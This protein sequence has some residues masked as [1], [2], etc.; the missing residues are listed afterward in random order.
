[1]Q[2]E[3]FTVASLRGSDRELLLHLAFLAKGDDFDLHLGEAIYVEEGWPLTR[4][5]FYGS[6]GTIFSVTDGFLHRGDQ[7]DEEEEREGMEDQED[8]EISEAESDI[9]MEE[10]DRSHFLLEKITT[11]N[12]VPLTMDCPELATL[13]DCK[14]ELWGYSSGSCDYTRF[15]IGGILKE[16]DPEN[17]LDRFQA[18]S[19]GGWLT[20]TWRR[21]SVLITPTD[22]S[23]TK[24]TLPTD[25]VDK[26]YRLLD[27]S[28]STLPS[29]EELIALDTA[30]RSLRGLSLIEIRSEISARVASCLRV[31]IAW[32]NENVFVHMLR[33]C[34]DHII[35]W[36][37]VQYL[38][39]GYRTFRWQRVE[40][41]YSKAVTSDISIRLRRELL[42]EMHAVATNAG[43]AE[44]IAWFNSQSEA[45]VEN[46][47]GFRI[48]MDEVDAVISAVK[49]RNDPLEVIR[50]ILLPNLHKKQPSDM[51]MWAT[52]FES[53]RKDSSFDQGQL[54]QVITDCIQHL[55]STFQPF[56]QSDLHS[57]IQQTVEHVANFISLCIAYDS[58]DTVPFFLQRLWDSSTSAELAVRIG[59]FNALLPQLH[60][61]LDKDAPELNNSFDEFFGKVFDLL[62]FNHSSERHGNLQI[63]SRYLYNPV[64]RLSECLSPERLE[65]LA[66]KDDHTLEDVTKFVHVYCA[67]ANSGSRARLQDI[68]QLCL[69]A[70]L[71]TFKPSESDGSKALNFIDLCFATDLR[72]TISRGF[73]T[74][75]NTS[76]SSQSNYI[77]SQLVTILKGLPELL[78][79]YGQPMTDTY[80]DFAVE[81]VKRYVRH[82]LG[83]SPCDEVTLQDWNSIGCG[84][85]DCQMLVSML[86]DPKPGAKNSFRRRFEVR[87]HLETQLTHMRCW[88]VSF[89]VV[90]G[91]PKTGK[92]P[93]M[94]VNIP[95]KLTLLPAWFKK[96]EEAQRLL[97]LF[98]DVVHQKQA[99]GE[100]YW[101]IAGMMTGKKRPPPPSC[102]PGSSKKARWKGVLD[103]NGSGDKNVRERKPNMSLPWKILLLTSALTVILCVLLGPSYVW[104]RFSRPYGFEYIALPVPMKIRRQYNINEDETDES[105]RQIHVSEKRLHSRVISTEITYPVCSA[106]ILNSSSKLLSDAEK[107]SEP[108]TSATMVGRLSNT[109]TLL[110]YW[111]GSYFPLVTTSYDLRYMGFP[112]PN[113]FVVQNADGFLAAA[114]AWTGLQR[115]KLDIIT[116]LYAV[117][118]DGSYEVD[119]KH[120]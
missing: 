105:G 36:M 2:S 33:E 11:L 119:R 116:L 81:V 102:D 97:E 42:A 73:E 63:A 20:Q 54:Y 35:S 89:V 98:G 69:D 120:L 94:R 15:V 117:V 70:R 49:G 34:G 37:S 118:A 85:V 74:Y 10:V 39:K 91:N 93:V 72:P 88:G 27:T 21:K 32:K 57:A 92:D 90:G 64:G 76:G 71:A 9:E 66:R 5:R 68:L 100:D 106:T 40:H 111:T 45:F 46:I 13:K 59:Y 110:G 43:D 87:Q 23:R 114:T 48:E 82:V 60:T 6:T 44:V 65:E 83:A 101:W 115:L 1:M 77:Q 99:L 104:D 51:R 38:V 16:G 67:S 12:G 96:L 22:S 84:C 8:G 78:K 50:N 61:C 17:D 53:L 112:T 79:S 47:H 31:V 55:S 14:R 80:L 19:D 107:T 26:A 28:D 86:H 62:L 108:G 24:F 4:H 52:L 30:L 56:N 95:P 103:G 18:Y 58:F 109:P 25:T 113:P 7:D 3:K 75:L 29:K 41:L